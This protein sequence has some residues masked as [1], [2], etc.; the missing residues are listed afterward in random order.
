[1]WKV[2]IGALG[3]LAWMLIGFA[4]ASPAQATCRPGSVTV[5]P[6]PHVEFPRCDPFPK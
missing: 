4:S 1:M 6:K 3:I 2:I 5:L